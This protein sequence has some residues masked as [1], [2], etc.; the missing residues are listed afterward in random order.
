MNPNKTFI[1]YYSYTTI[2][3][4]NTLTFILFFYVL[5]GKVQKILALA[6]ANISFLSYHLLLIT[7]YYTCIV[8]AGGLF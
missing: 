7:L 6:S 8:T 2:L 4:N 3:K 1:S 5:Q